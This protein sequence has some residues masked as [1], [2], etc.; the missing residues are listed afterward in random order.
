MKLTKKHLALLLGGLTFGSIAHAQSSLTFYGS[1]DEGITY[2]SNEANKKNVQ[3]GVVAVP[4]KYGFKGSEDLGDGLKA[5]FQLEN[6]YFSNTGAM[7]ISGDAFS[8][9]AWVGLSSTTAG[10]LTAGRQWDLT[11]DVFTPNAN[12][13]VQYNNYLYHP[14]NLDNSAVTDVNNSLKY[15]SPR[16]H[17]WFVQGMYAFSDATNLQGRYFG[18]TLRYVSG[19]LSFGAVYSNTN[20]KTYALNSTLGYTSFLGQNLAG[21]ATFRASNTAIFGVGSTYQITPKWSVHALANDVRIE[22]PAAVG[23]VYNAELGVDYLMTPDN[24]ISLGGF[25][26]GV[27]GR[28]YTSIGLAELYHLSVR[29]MIYAETTTQIT[30]H[31]TGAVMPSLVTSSNSRQTAIRVGL[32]HYF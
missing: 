26:A 12:G 9:Y 7:A 16:F 32:Q 19:P 29:T 24:S 2:I 1:I 13:A 23:T 11:N 21:G 18:A 8:R 3:T 4:D 28:Q 25:H 5:N 27:D 20:N 10:S 14:G 15:T 17:G 30:S 31:G 22:T 6:G